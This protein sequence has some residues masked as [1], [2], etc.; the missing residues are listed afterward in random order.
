MEHLKI[1]TCN[2]RNQPWG[3]GT[4]AFVHRLGMIMDKMNREMPDIVAFQ[5]ILP[6]HLDALRRIMPDYLFLGQLRG[7]SYDGEGL[8]TAIR[9]CSLDVLGLET[10]WLSPTPYEPGSRYAEQSRYPRICMMTQLR[11]RESGA[12]FRVYNVHLDHVS[13][14]ARVL[15]M[16][17][18]LR[19]MRSYED[20]RSMPSFVL[21]DFNALPDSEAVRI[22]AEEGGLC[23]LTSHIPI[24]FCAYGKDASRLRKIDYIFASPTVAADAVSVW[25]DEHEG[26]YLSDHYPICATVSFGEENA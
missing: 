12:C 9:T 13:E 19:F 18:V 17:D 6:F 14:Q 15:G 20:K 16:R 22:C 5:E 1:V 4:N 24:S 8:Y 7:P 26:I 2:A 10:V 21:G 23:D 11:H 3:D 25:T